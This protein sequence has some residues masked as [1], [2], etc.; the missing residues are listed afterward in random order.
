[1]TGHCIKDLV[2]YSRS[3]RSRKMGDQ[4]LPLE[5]SWYIGNCIFAILYGIQLCM[6]FMSAYFL[7]TSSKTDNS[8]CFY[9]IYSSILLV[10]ITIAMSCNL[11]FG[12]MMWIEHRDVPGGPVEFFSDNIAAWYNTFGTAADVTADVLSNAMMLYRC[13]VFW[14]GSTHYI[15]AFPALLFLAA[16]AMGIVSTIQSGLPGGDWFGSGVSLGTPWLV[17]T[18]VFNVVTTSMISFRL[19]LVS[20]TMRSVLSKERAQLYTGVI[21]ILVESALPFTLLGI[22]YVVLYIRSDP[23]SLALADIWGA[24]VALSPQAIILR[25]AMGS[26]WSRKTVT[27]FGSASSHTNTAVVFGTGSGPT[28][29]GIALQTFNQESKASTGAFPVT[30]KVPASVFDV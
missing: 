25:V 17:L 2:W 7:S 23:E 22:V 3:S 20:R 30:S 4:V 9:I 10:L 18:L 8:R 5:R 14:S 15:V 6:A 26:A 11:F 16:T 21:A 12:Q 19:F 24:F 1:M 27:Q 28:P 13:Y 29:A